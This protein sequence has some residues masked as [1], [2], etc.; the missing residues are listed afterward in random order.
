MNPPDHQRIGSKHSYKRRSS[1]SRTITSHFVPR[2]PVNDPPSFIGGHQRKVVGIVLNIRR[3]AYTHMQSLK[4]TTARFGSMRAKRGIN[5]T[6][7]VGSDDDN[8]SD[9]R[10]WNIVRQ[11]KLQGTAPGWSTGRLGGSTLVLTRGSGFESSFAALS[12][13]SQI[14]KDI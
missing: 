5:Y 10:R 11:K 14:V 2:S 12:A 1:F 4:T 8:E 9:I 13:F 7:P 6:W 3:H